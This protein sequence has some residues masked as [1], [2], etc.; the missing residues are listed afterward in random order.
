MALKV[1]SQVSSCL[2]SCSCDG[3][4]ELVV[5]VLKF[6]TSKNKTWHTCDGTSLAISLYK[7]LFITANPLPSGYPPSC[8]MFGTPLFL[9]SCFCAPVFLFTTYYINKNTYTSMFEFIPAS[10]ICASLS[11]KVESE[12]FI[13]NPESPDKQKSNQ[14]KWQHI[15]MDFEHPGTATRPYKVGDRLPFVSFLGEQK[16]QKPPPLKQKSSRLSNLGSFCKAAAA[17]E[18]ITLGLK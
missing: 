5:F 15:K 17:K 18:A 13:W 14:K 3:L 16:S 1:P 11:I 12:V 4:H 2:D 9:P 6:R 7:Y 10:S 8:Y